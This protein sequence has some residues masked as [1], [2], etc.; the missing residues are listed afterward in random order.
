MHSAVMSTRL[1]HIAAD[2]D[3]SFAVELDSDDPVELL[4]ALKHADQQ[5]DAWRRQYVAAARERGVSW[6]AIGDGL[7]MTKQAAWEYYNA[8]IRAILDRAAAM[9]ELTDDEAMA[10]AVREV[11]AVRR[12]HYD[13]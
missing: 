7:G 13:T 6:S 3:M 11:R 12:G 9:S 2:A 8:D 10:V 4:R 1:K 5:L